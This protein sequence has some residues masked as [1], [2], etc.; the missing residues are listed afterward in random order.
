MQSSSIDLHNFG[1]GLMSWNICWF[2]WTPISLVSLGLCDFPWGP[3]TWS[4]SALFGRGSMSWLEQMSV[5]W[6][7]APIQFVS[8]LHSGQEWTRDGFMGSWMLMD[9]C[10]FTSGYLQSIT[11]RS[12]KNG[13]RHSPF[14][15]FLFFE[16]GRTWRY[17]SIY[18]SQPID[19][20]R[21]SNQVC[22]TNGQADLIGK[23][24]WK[25]P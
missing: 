10:P 15:L 14:F 18:I 25:R 1:W 3:F 21:T 17:K 4:R 8:P 19:P 5:F 16:P 12:K 24:M 22:L 9:L 2:R 20:H 7:L 6:L 11:F 13:K 23:L